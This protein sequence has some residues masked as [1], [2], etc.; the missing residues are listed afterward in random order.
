MKKVLFIIA[1]IVAFVGANAQSYDKLSGK[2]ENG[3][4]NL[5]FAIDNNGTV[6]ISVWVDTDGKPSVNMPP[7]T[8]SEIVNDSTILMTINVAQ[9]ELNEIKGEWKKIERSGKISYWSEDGTMFISDN[10]LYSILLYNY[11]VEKDLLSIKYFFGRHSPSFFVFIRE[12]TPE[13]ILLDKTWVAVDDKY[14]SSTKDKK[15]IEFSAEKWN[16]SY[17][18]QDNN[19]F[20]YRIFSGEGFFSATIE[21]GVWELSAEGKILGLQKWNDVINAYDSQKRYSIQELNEGTCILKNESTNSQLILINK[22]YLDKN[23]QF[24]NF[25]KLIG[26]WEASDNSSKV[27]FKFFANGSIINQGK[28]QRT[29]FNSWRLKDNNTVE[30]EVL[31]GDMSFWMPWSIAELTND[32]LV[33]RSGEVQIVFGRF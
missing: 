20:V 14:L 11:D 6:K 7:I 12:K 26:N 30:F 5:F 23:N 1:L 25:V 22:E 27:I 28:S 32:Q 3:E 10:I 19:K 4:K 9:D 15:E 17:D 16:F 33:L 31:N 21:N 18:S 13:Q 29:K 2:W 24:S 8:S